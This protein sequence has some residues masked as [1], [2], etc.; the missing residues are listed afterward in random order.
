MNYKITILTPVLIFGVLT[1]YATDVNQAKH[2]ADN[3]NLQRNTLLNDWVKDYG[4][5]NNLPCSIVQTTKEDILLL[6]EQ[7]KLEKLGRASQ[8]KQFDEIISN[9]RFGYLGGLGKTLDSDGEN[10]IVDA[11]DK[12][13]NRCSLVPPSFG[14]WMEKSSK[15]FFCIFENS[16]FHENFRA[17]HFEFVAEYN[18]IKIKLDIFP[19][20]AHHERLLSELRKKGINAESSDIAHWI[21]TVEIM[22]NETQKIDELFAVLNGYLTREYLQE[23]P[24]YTLGQMKDRA[25][26]AIRELASKSSEELARRKTESDQRIQ[27]IIDGIEALTNYNP[28]ISPA[29][30]KILGDAIRNLDRL[31]DPLELV[32][33]PIWCNGP[34]G[35]SF[36]IAPRPKIPQA[37]SGESFDR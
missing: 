5:P 11:G 31:D 7:G 12:V 24:A 30:Y 26:R 21:V 29:D 18:K 14:T 10:E 36:S 33:P 16:N 32:R 3:I 6:K 19:D 25:G 34:H 2:I 4:S 37:Q 15:W 23:I 13:K 28:R 1:A 9:A 22:T 20:G 27:Q 35:K 8:V 17:V